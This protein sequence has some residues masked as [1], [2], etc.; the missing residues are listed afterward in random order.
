MP[1]SRTAEEILRR[2]VFLGGPSRAEAAVHVEQVEARAPRYAAWPEWADPLLVERLRAG[3]M[4]QPWA[5]QAAA[6]ELLHAGRHTIMATGTASGKS[7]GYLLPAL[8]RL[9]ADSGRPVSG[10]PP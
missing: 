5:H 10:A 4:E 9:L 3:G 7:A 2:L 6:A 8:S 1:R